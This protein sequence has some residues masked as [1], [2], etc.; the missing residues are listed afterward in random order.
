MIYLAYVTAA[1]IGVAAFAAAPRVL[2]SRPTL[3][4]GARIMAASLAAMYSSV[5]VAVVA[6][7]SAD[8]PRPALAWGLA[9]MAAAGLVV[10]VSGL[11]WWSGSTAWLLRL[12]GWLLLVIPTIVPSSI[13]LLLPVA[14]PLTALLYRAPRSAHVRPTAGDD[15]VVRPDEDR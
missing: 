14:A 3:I 8:D 1:T 12:A 4:A 15:A 7:A 5:F 11:I 9:G 13:S 6:F 2:R 10:Y